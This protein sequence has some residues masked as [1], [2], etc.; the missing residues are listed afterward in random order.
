MFLRGFCYSDPDGIREGNPVRGLNR[1]LFL[2]AGVAHSMI[3]RSCEREN[4]LDLIH[5]VIQL[6]NRISGCADCFQRAKQYVVI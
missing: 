1:H 2:T 4:S 3:S 5:P 6:S